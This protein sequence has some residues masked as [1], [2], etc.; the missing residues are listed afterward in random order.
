MDNSSFIFACLIARRLG[1]QEKGASVQSLEA[2]SRGCIAS[3][4][5]PDAA[6]D[7]SVV[8]VQVMKLWFISDTHNLHQGLEVPEVDGV[9]H[10]GDESDQ[11]NPLLNEPEA[12]RFFQ[13]Y[14]SLDIPT[15][16]Y[17]PGNHSTAVEQGLIKRSDYPGIR[18]LIHESAQWQGL[19]L[20]GSPYTPEFFDWAYMKPRHELDA[21]WQAIPDDTDI[22]VTHGPPKGILDVTRDMNASGLVHVGS[23][24]LRKHVVERIQPRFHAF[25]HIHDENGI[26]NFGTLTR[27]ETTFINC[28]CCD[29][30]GRLKNN[31]FIVEV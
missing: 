23:K 5:I 4:T 11:G 20:F 29:L 18:F 3:A 28:S 13:W 27:G 10:C 7:G 16:F 30:R 6:S 17:I 24:S 2:G 22:L 15:K 25:G 8:R 26:E 31:G 14:A 21:Y 9:I 19:K 12:R 1:G